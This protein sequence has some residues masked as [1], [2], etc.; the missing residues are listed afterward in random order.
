MTTTIKGDDYEKLFGEM[1]ALS[2]ATDSSVTL[3]F[4]AYRE[5]GWHLSMPK[6]KSAE[7]GSV[8]LTSPAQA[9]EKLAE[10]VQELIEEATGNREAQRALMFRLE[11]VTEEGA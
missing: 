8:E 11:G 4:T 10:R 7:H 6:K 9:R 5:R 3:T 2:R 1:E